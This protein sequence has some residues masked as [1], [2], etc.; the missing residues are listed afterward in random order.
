MTKFSER[1]GYR[2]PDPPITV[3]ED[4]PDDVRGFVVQYAYQAGMKPS[5][6]RSLVCGLLLVRP[7]ANNWSEYPN[8]ETEVQ[9]HVD[10]CPWY[11]VYDI[12]E[13]V[14]EAL[15]NRDPSGTRARTAR[16]YLR[17]D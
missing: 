3:H 1:R 13:A 17:D 4:A 9:R 6:M 12:A 10:T 5:D 11:N 2:V 15:K 16:S 14:Y 7:N 8:I